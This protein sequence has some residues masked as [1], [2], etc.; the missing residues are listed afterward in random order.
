LLNLP[1]SYEACNISSDEEYKL[2]PLT[3][4][5]KD[6]V[7]M[8][9]TEAT[10]VNSSKSSL[11]SQEVAKEELI[12]NS[13]NARTTK[14][15]IKVAGQ[16]KELINEE[17][18]TISSDKVRSTHS[19]QSQS[20]S[21]PKGASSLDQANLT[22]GI[23]Q[24]ESPSSS[25]KCGSPTYQA[26]AAE[27]STTLNQTPKSPS[28]LPERT[29]SREHKSSQQQK[30]RTRYSIYT[31]SGQEPVL[32]VRLRLYHEGSH[33]Q[34]N[35]L[36]VHVREHIDLVDSHRK[37]DLVGKK[38]HREVQQDFDSQSGRNKGR[39]ES[40]NTWKRTKGANANSRKWEQ[41]DVI[42]HGVSSAAAPIIF[43]TLIAMLT[44]Y[45]FLKTPD[46]NANKYKYRY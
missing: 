24:R 2:V 29:E 44:Y 1:S 11:F 41:K 40:S 23:L 39:G 17:V 22:E 33:S 14:A 46:P 9:Q 32:S 42:R 26:N 15:D 27:E 38:R 21:S 4:K 3:Y 8:E 34:N 37:G 31:S 30:M 28:A 13:C 12:P 6:T 20:T 43:F 25:R 10:E 35:H 36:D 45:C 7:E 16:D 19:V 18:I 5:N